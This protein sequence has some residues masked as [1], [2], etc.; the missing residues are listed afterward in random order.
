M[1][2][3]VKLRVDELMD[4]ASVCKCPQC[5][6]DVIALALNRLPPRYVTCI[7]GDVFTRFEAQTFQERAEVVSAILR[8]AETV[9][10][11]PRHG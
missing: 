3:L 2:E 4:Y 1:E 10:Q 7:Q 11:N 9:R 5:R 6:S 8:A